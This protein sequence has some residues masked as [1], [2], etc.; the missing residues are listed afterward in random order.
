MH[1]SNPLSWKAV[2]GGSEMV[3]GIG[4]GVP[5]PIPGRAGPPRG[6]GVGTVW[7]GKESIVGPGP[8]LALGRP[9]AQAS[10]GTFGL[11]GIQ[12]RPVP[13]SIPGRARHLAEL[14]FQ[15]GR[16][17]GRRSWRDIQNQVA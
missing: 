9:G 5:Q 1:P 2:Y 13:W 4:E 8:W 14:G 7:P 17:W 11:V 6:W 15:V 12:A 10:P 16:R 3:L